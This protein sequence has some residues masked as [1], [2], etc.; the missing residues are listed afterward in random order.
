MGLRYVKHL[1]GVFYG[2]SLQKINR[3]GYEEGK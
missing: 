2:E 1:G 3:K